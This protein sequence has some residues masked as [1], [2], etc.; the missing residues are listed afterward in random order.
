MLSLTKK[1]EY[2]LIAIC[3]LARVGREKIVSARDIHEAHG[4]PLPLLMNV[5]KR[6]NHAGYVNSTRGAHGGYVLAVPPTRLTMT[7][8]IEAV[9]GPV[10]FV[11]CVDLNKQNRKC[12]LT[13]SC[14]IQG[15]VHRVHRRL[16]DFLT[17]VT[18]AE[19]AFDNHPAPAERAK[20]HAE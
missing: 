19:I 20:V 12:A 14:P 13:K 16:R 4:V 8:L 1:T 7:Q 18:I 9:E 3:H 17:D 11:R 2:A 6:L 10:Q 15:A 5:L